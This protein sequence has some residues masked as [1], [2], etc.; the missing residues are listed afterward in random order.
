MIDIKKD[1]NFFKR[2]KV[3]IFIIL[4]YIIL[5]L[6]FFRDIQN[7]SSVIFSTGDALDYISQKHISLEALK[8]FERVFWNGYN[9]CGVPFED[10]YFFYPITLVLDLIFP[11]SLAHNLQVL[12]HYSLAGIFM[13]LFLN[14][15][16]LDKLASFTGGM[17][18]MFSGLMISNKSTSMAQTIVWFPL[19]LL[20]L[21]KY[22]KSRR[23][24]YVL[25][26]SIFYGLSFFGHIQI[27]LYG[28]IVILFYI[29]FHTFIYK[30]GGNYYFLLSSIIFIIAIL[31]DGFALMEISY[32]ISSTLRGTVDKA[33]D[34]FSIGSLSPK[35]L[36]I[37]IFP[38]FFGA[39]HP[40]ISGIPHFFRWFGQ[41]DSLAM[42][43]YFGI[44]SIPL[45][46]FGIFKKNKYKYLWIFIMLFSL[47]L[48]LGKYTPFYKLMYYVPFF[49]MGR[50]PT[51]NWF[52]FGLAFSILCGLGFDY[53]IKLDKDKVKRIVIGLIIFLG[54]LLSSFFIFFIFFNSRFKESI[55]NFYR[56][57]LRFS[58]FDGRDIGEIFQE[59]IK[60]T[61]YSI[62]MPL[63]VIVAAI[64]LLVLILFKKN[65]FVY[66][67][68][69]IFIFF[70]LYSY[71]RF[72]E[73]NNEN[74]FVPRGE[75]KYSQEL[76]FL[77]NKDELFRIFPVAELP[78]AYVYIRNRSIYY[79]LYYVFGYGYTNPEFN[80]ITILEDDSYER[81]PNWE[82]SLWRSSLK[83]NIIISML[84]TRYI[85]LP[86]QDDTSNFMDSI[87]KSFKTDEG[88]ILDKETYIET[89]FDGFTFSGDKSEIIISG[90][91]NVLKVY[92]TPVGIESNEDYIISFEIKRNNELD[93]SLHF[94]FYGSDYDSPD[95][96]FILSPED[97]SEEYIEVERIIDSG[98]IPVDIDI[99]FRM[100]TSSGGDVSIKDLEINQAEKYNNYEIKY[101]SDDVLVLENKN[102]I[103]RFYFVNEVENVG[104]LQEVKK[105]LWEKDILYDNDRFD[106]EET[107]LVQDV[108]F[109]KRRFDAENASVSIIDYGNHNIILEVKS[110]EDC[111]LVFSD[112]FSPEWKVYIDDIENNIYRTNGILKGV[113]I[114]EGTHK[115]EFNYTAKYFLPAAIMSLVSLSIVIAIII[116][117]LLKRKKSLKPAPPGPDDRN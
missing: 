79:G 113:Y 85:V 6:I 54:S 88:S 23:I 96:E 55:I 106:P 51:R 99:F 45:L 50:S 114:P 81:N 111:F 74:I 33:Y 47:L 91:Q 44:V 38:Y 34:F 70:D 42:F 59:S 24:E 58:Y 71:G 62:Y 26:A 83:N 11:L 3:N 25:I 93:D 29:L 76:E 73:K 90:S 116:L 57:V 41:E 13:F 109:S 117:L 92:K 56:P 78:N 40:D 20:F 101:S 63:I 8:D 97:I 94:D 68:I 31:I 35:L 48:V 67:L 10:S 108:D 53:F 16:K 19:I 87:S 1:I 98:E 82:E 86:K 49:N 5:P 102:F 12:L 84:N 66:I 112:N 46:I 32:G 72:D 103:P 69:I 4:I 110:A 77:G 75:I 52:E 65:K 28:S 43:I 21:E 115:L 64:S 105:I 107:A 100:F 37:L 2:N 95:Q 39:K 7:I 104:D 89:E 22:R 30:G 18:F 80:Y 14:E 27:F 9:N 36:P 17:I 61:N 15:H 60:L